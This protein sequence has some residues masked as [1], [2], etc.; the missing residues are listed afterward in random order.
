MDFSI[1]DFVADRRAATPSAAAEMATP[2]RADLGRRVR[3]LSDRL[4]NALDGRLARERDRIAGLAA[5]RV[6]TAPEGAVQRRRELLKPTA[7]RLERAMRHGLDV[8]GRE[9]RRLC[10]QM[11]ALSPLAVLGRGYALVRT[12][13]GRLIPRAAGLAPGAA[14]AVQF[15]DGTAH[16]RV[17][18]VE[19]QNTDMAPDGADREADV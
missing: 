9:L 8:R 19:I 10:A 6:L 12:P 7:Q 14:V 15:A 2:D 11:Q 13:D 4:D 17:E 3:G 18:R 1:S 16:A 5:R